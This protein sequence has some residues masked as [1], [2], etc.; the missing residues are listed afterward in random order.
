MSLKRPA[1]RGSKYS[2]KID[3]KAFYVAYEGNDDEKEYFEAFQNSIKRRFAKNIKFIAVEKSTTD[4][5]PEHVLKDLEDKLI[6]DGI[7]YKRNSNIV[8]YIVID[9]D[10]HFRDTHN[11][12][13]S[14]VLQK[15]RQKG[16]KVALTNP[17]FELWLMCH[18][19]DISNSSSKFKSKLLENA[20]VSRHKTF[21]K[22]EWGKIKGSRIT[23]DLISVVGNALLHE[24]KLNE[25]CLNINSMPP[26][27]LYSNVGDI[28]K[29]IQECGIDI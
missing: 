27:G 14:N 7:K 23:N 3:P 12:E 9:T 4:A 1:S 20:K 21:A 8:T 28:F 18:L 29:E 22:I 25:Q 15:C 6:S 19:K 5:E 16:I 11:R 13:T 2:K 17:C 26:N 24:A 10:H